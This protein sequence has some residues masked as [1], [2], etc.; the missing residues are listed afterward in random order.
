MDG[1]ERRI[2]DPDKWVR[3]WCGSLTSVRVHVGFGV[4]G[5]LGV[6]LGVLSWVWLERLC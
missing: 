6:W 1:F 4:R 2:E 5:G 3:G